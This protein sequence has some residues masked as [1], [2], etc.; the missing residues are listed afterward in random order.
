[1][2]I[3]IFVFPG[4]FSEKNRVYFVWL[5][6]RSRPIS[7]LLIY[8]FRSVIFRRRPRPIT[9]KKNNRN[10][11]YLLQRMSRRTPSRGWMA[12]VWSKLRNNRRGPPFSSSTVNDVILH[13]KQ[14]FSRFPT[15]VVTSS[16]VKIDSRFAI[17]RSP[18]WF[19]FTN[20]ALSVL[21]NFFERENI[22]NSM[23]VHV[24]LVRKYWKFEWK[25]VR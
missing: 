14:P 23:S 19:K 20:A 1:M 12:I 17:H 24:V 6:R 16:P 13:C 18:H 10:E 8:S 3:Y 9:Q 25:N 7:S 11:I 21:S 4:V 15:K 2:T 5:R 22:L